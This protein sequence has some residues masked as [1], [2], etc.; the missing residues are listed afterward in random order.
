MIGEPLN[1]TACLTKYTD[2]AKRATERSEVQAL[3]D[4]FLARN[5]HDTDSALEAMRQWLRNKPQTND[6][7]HGPEPRVDCG[8]VQ[9]RVDYLGASPNC[10]ERTILYSALGELI[11]PDGL[12][13]MATIKTPFGLHTFPLEDGNPI[14]LDPTLPRNALLFGLHTMRNTRNGCT[15]AANTLAPDETMTPHEMVEFT[16]DIADE[17]ASH[18]RNGR[19]RVTSTERSLRRLWNGQPIAQNPHDFRNAL[20]DIAWTFALAEQAA[21]VSGG[22]GL[23][24]VRLSSMAV[25]SLLTNRAYAQARNFSFSIGGRKINVNL[26][27]ATR[28]LTKH[29]GSAASE[30]LSTAEKVAKSAGPLAGPAIKTYLLSH[31]IPT[32]AVNA[33]AGK[34]LKSANLSPGPLG[35]KTPP[36]GTLDALAFNAAVKQITNTVT[37][38]KG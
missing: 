31:G 24:A 23:D 37:P 9:Q 15:T 16:L 19:A 12:R 27:K 26:K 36:T 8:T 34:V 30:V 10:S 4:S 33:V 35:F 18:Y 29:L 2:V 17:P 22:H 7:G 32:Q 20:S 5:H 28:S 13:Q 6:T 21:R 14:V 1:D 25:Q 11:D 38:K 3:A